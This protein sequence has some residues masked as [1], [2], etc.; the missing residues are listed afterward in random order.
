LNYFISGTNDTIEIE[1][2]EEYLDNLQD[3]NEFF[4]EFNE[5]DNQLN[6]T[7]SIRNGFSEEDKAYLGKKYK[8]L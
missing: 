5:R 8:I 6:E 3:L 1:E 7:D 4:N 2:M